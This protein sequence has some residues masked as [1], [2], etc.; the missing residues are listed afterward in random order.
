MV[1]GYASFL[2]A[3]GGGLFSVSVLEGGGAFISA[4][5]WAVLRS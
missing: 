1:I 3:S 2:D 5:F 4:S